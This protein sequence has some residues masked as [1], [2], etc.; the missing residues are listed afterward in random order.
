MLAKHLNYSVRST[1][2]FARWGGE[3]F[4]I[5]FPETTKGEAKIICEKIRLSVEILTHPTA[6]AITVS[7]GVA[8]YEKNDTIESMFKR[9]DEALYEAKETGR[10][11][12]CV[13]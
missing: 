9:C 12:V 11:K 2:I 13:K 10:N 6:G 7:F 3:E 4:V 1:D 8:Q 5:L